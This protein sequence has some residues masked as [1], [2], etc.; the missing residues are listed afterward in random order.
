MAY[1]S[2]VDTTAVT[3]YTTRTATYIVSREEDAA[4]NFICYAVTNSKGYLER[5]FPDENNAG[6]A[7][8]YAIDAL[9]SIGGK[10]ML[11]KGAFKVTRTKTVIIDVSANCVLEGQGLYSTIIEVAEVFPGWTSVLV[12]RGGLVRDLTLDGKVDTYSQTEGGHLAGMEDNAWWEK[13]RFKSYGYSVRSGAKN[14]LFRDCIIEDM[15]G[16]KGLDCYDAKGTR[17]EGL[18]IYK[19]R[20]GCFGVHLWNP[21]RDITFIGGEAKE[22]GDHPPIKI[23]AY[24]SRPTN[25]VI[26]GM[27]FV[28]NGTSAI[29][30]GYYAPSNVSVKNCVFDNNGYVSVIGYYN[31]ITIEGCTHANQD[32]AVDIGSGRI[33]FV[34]NTVIDMSHAAVNPVHWSGGL[35]QTILLPSVK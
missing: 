30:A 16:D 11:S 22:N 1:P 18:K 32:K 27:Q 2:Y 24:D 7:I 23:G 4:G 8:Q 19:N 15:A 29:S 34:N 31:T 26:D 35:W 13:V 10:V 3:E 21:N 5:A 25:I 33:N 12:N 28:D 20:D 9:P 6:A 17:F 14:N